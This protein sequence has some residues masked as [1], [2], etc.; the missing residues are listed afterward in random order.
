M[1]IYS[2]EKNTKFELEFNLPGLMNGL[3]EN[4]GPLMI[5]SSEVGDL[6]LVLMMNEQ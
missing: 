3:I 1:G 5:L 6:A 4:G 2:F